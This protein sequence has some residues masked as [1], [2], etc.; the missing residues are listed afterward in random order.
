MG[1]FAGTL[2]C[3]FAEGIAT[4]VVI[5]VADLHAI[6]GPKRFKPEI[7]MRTGVPGVANGLAWPPCGR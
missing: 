1:Q 7:A 6:L 3:A 5:T 4:A 2:R